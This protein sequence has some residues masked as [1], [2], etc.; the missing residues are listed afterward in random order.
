MRKV[1]AIFCSILFFFAVLSPAAFAEDFN[2][3]IFQSPAETQQEVEQLH[4]RAAQ[5]NKEHQ[6][7]L[8]SYRSFLDLFRIDKKITKESIE[9]K[10]KGYSMEALS[11]V[12]LYANSVQKMLDNFAKQYGN[13]LAVKKDQNDLHTVAVTALSMEMNKL[14][15][16]HPPKKK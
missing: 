14:N 3:G 1:K 10:L 4:A 11:N 8:S 6:A 7:L 13:N 2:T 5:L 16:K 12:A 9:K 15:P